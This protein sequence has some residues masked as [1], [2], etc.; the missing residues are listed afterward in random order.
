MAVAEAEETLTLGA[1]ALRLGL[2]F[3]LVLLN[4]FF[5][6]AEFS[7]VAARR[8]RL[9]QM[10][11]EGDRA[12]RRVRDAQDQLPRIISGTQLGV[13]LAS[14]A[15][16]WLGEPSVAALIDLGLRSL[17]VHASPATEHT[18]AAVVIGFLVITFLHIVIGELGPKSVSLV[19]AEGVAKV[20]ARPILLFVRVTSPFIWVLNGS[21]NRLLRLFGIQPVSEEEQVHSPEELRLLVMQARAH[22]TLDES[23]SAMLA[24]VFDFH[25]KKAYDVMRP[26]TEVVA[27]DQDATEEEV[28]EVLRTE[29]Y[30][31]Y[32]VYHESLDD[33]V[34]VFL[35]KD[36]W[37]RDGDSPFSL[38]DYLREPLYI[39][40]T[41]AAERVLD[42]L[43]KT[44]AHLAV[45]L[46]EY[47]GTAGIVTME[48]LVEE[49]VGDINDE[50]D[51]REREAF[52]FEGVLELAGALSLVDVRSDYHLR[53]PDGDWT[54]LGGYVFGTLGRL[55]KIGDRVPFPGG[56]LEVV[57]MDGRRVAAV[58]VHRAPAPAAS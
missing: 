56:E 49:V 58:R 17:G 57:A 30:S 45:V 6:A 26:R 39:P 44:R 1:I 12:A 38:K 22:G 34:G 35:A 28:R 21:A 18:A 41:R 29:R 54:T 27:L 23:D 24:G 16:G 48:D 52:E 7:L 13:T 10:A 32:P 40:S 31:R 36:Y 3:L 46:D 11:A 15:L 19:N 9:D 47:G 14:L 53:I 43:R 25:E 51:Q 20:I 37:L 8:S 55:P 2:V 33:V 42:D 5:V 50:Y 4:G